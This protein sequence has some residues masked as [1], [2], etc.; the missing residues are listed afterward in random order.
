MKDCPAGSSINPTTMKCRKDCKITHERDSKGKCVK[1]GGKAKKELARIKREEKKEKA[2]L[3]K[4]LARIQREE[5][6]EKALLKKELARIQREEKRKLKEGEK[7]QRKIIAREKKEELRKKRELARQNKEK[8]NQERA[9]NQNRIP[10]FI[11]DTREP[12]EGCDISKLEVRTMSSLLGVKYENKYRTCE[13][14]SKALKLP[15]GAIITKFITAGSSGIIANVESPSG[16]SYIAKVMRI[17]DEGAP[18]HTKVNKNLTGEKFTWSS[19]H[20]KDMEI[21]IKSHGN[22]LEIHRKTNIFGD[23]VG[24]DMPK[25]ISHHMVDLPIG[26]FGVIIMERVKGTYTL[27]KLLGSK[28]EPFERKRDVFLKFA[29]VIGTLYGKGIC[30]GDAHPGNVIVIDGTYDDMSIIDFGKSFAYTSR[31]MDSG[32]GTIY[33]PD[34]L[35]SIMLHTEEEK[36]KI[37]DTYQIMMPFYFGESDKQDFVDRMGGAGVLKIVRDIFTSRRCILAQKYSPGVVRL[38]DQPCID[39]PVYD[40]LTYDDRD[41]YGHTLHLMPYAHGEYEYMNHSIVDAA[42]KDKPHV[43]FHPYDLS[44]LKSFIVDTDVVY[45]YLSCG[46]PELGIDNSIQKGGEISVDW[47]KYLA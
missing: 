23:I 11:P 43:I 16:E 27:D 26:K 25:I 5:K 30:H 33:H 9:E 46:I 1:I 32:S 47:K 19:I 45:S 4:E 31:F 7:L 34:E 35:H 36:M 12:A 41:T 17:N 6:K 20:T 14:I 2:L 38:Y 44:S 18:I 8:Q 28:F 22:I 15:T 13:F 24:V 29:K 10:S 40:K 39:K 37:Y 3:K 21:E 42:V